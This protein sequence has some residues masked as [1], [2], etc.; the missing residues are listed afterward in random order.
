MR[1]R[2]ITN[3]SNYFSKHHYYMLIRLAHQVLNMFINDP[4]FWNNLNIDELINVGWFRQA[5]YH[6]SVKGI[7]NLIKREMYNWAV[8]ERKKAVHEKLIE[9]I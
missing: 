4:W 9:V 2:P 7:S 5:R 3:K 1:G 8:K 6:K